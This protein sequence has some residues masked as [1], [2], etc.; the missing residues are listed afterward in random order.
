MRPGKLNQ[1]KA[2]R[3]KTL[4]SRGKGAALM[5][6]LPLL[7]VEGIATLQRTPSKGKKRGKWN[8]WIEDSADW[9]V[10]T[11]WIAEGELKERS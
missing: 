5:A 8:W 7:A 2:A 6:T 9:M 4:S 10:E 3:Q 1:L 11:K